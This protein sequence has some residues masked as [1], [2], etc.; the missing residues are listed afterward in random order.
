[1]NPE[2]SHED[3]L[4]FRIIELLKKDP[5]AKIPEELLAMRVE[6]ARNSPFDPPSREEIIYYEQKL[7]YLISKS[8]GRLSSSKPAPDK[9]DD[10][11][12]EDSPKLAE[13]HKAANNLKH[14]PD[15]YV[16]NPL[17]DVLAEQERQRRKKRKAWG[18]WRNLTRKELVGSRAWQRAIENFINRELT[19]A[20]I[21]DKMPFQTTFIP[22][23]FH[24]HL[25]IK[26]K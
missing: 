1:M 23:L 20:E 7:K 5:E 24:P 18:H 8:K 21:A 16:P 3:N 22:Y 26:N 12:T 25:V 14:Y 2:R 13:I 10:L 19:D 4:E 17:Q 6:F 15:R 11:K 9:V